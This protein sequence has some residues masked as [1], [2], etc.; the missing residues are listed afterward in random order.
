MSRRPADDPRPPRD[1]LVAVVG[2]LAGA[3]LVL[4]GALRIVEATPQARDLLGVEL[5]AGVAAAKVLCGR[6]KE[7]PVAEA[8][9]AARK[10]DAIIAAPSGAG[11]LRVRASPVG[12]GS[13]AGWLLVLSAEPAADEV[14]LFHGMWTADPATR[15]LFRLVER[16]A[17]SDA[18]VLVRGETGSGK[19]RVAEALH[20][21]SRRAAGPYRAINCAAMP[22]ALLES[23]LFGHVKGAFTGAV[24]DREGL[25]A[26]ADGGT[27]FLDE[28]AEMPLE[29]Q[30]KMLRVLET[31]EFTPVGGRD[32]LRA[33]VRIVAATHRALRREAEAGRFRADLMYRLRVIPLFLPPLRDRGDD[34]VLLARKLTEAMNG[35][36]ER[37]ITGIA[38]A[39][40]DALRRHDWPGN[41]RE[42]KNALAFAYVVGEGPTLVEADLPP[43][44]SGAPPTVQT[45]STE[46]LDRRPTEVERILAALDRAA[47]S[48]TRAAQILGW[49]R[50]TLW[51][52]MRE[53]GIDGG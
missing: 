44:I 47:G 38:P 25:F 8:L 4:D 9:A 32:P 27:L 23:E 5:P 49:S 12:Q 11:R 34:V 2:E 20:R 16:A 19:E 24:R 36:N 3:A 22:Q 39:A 52:R 18:T 13:A 7:R 28:V 45:R 37:Q 33:D 43:E 48:R 31:G 51:R 10:V 46:R 29:V 30:A 42:L 1:L 40:A 14:E 53:L 35:A 6:S 17:R 21:L 50:V 15:R 41:V 26:S